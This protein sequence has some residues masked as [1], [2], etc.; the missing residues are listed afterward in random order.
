MRS[1]RCRKWI[2]SRIGNGHYWWGI[3]DLRRPSALTGDPLDAPTAPRLVRTGGND[4]LQ[5]EDGTTRQA[6]LVFDVP[7]KPL[8]GLTLEFTRGRIEHDNVITGGLGVLFILQNELSNAGDLV[9][10]ETGTQNY[11]NN[12]TAPI[13]V[14]SGPAGAVTAIQ[15]GQ[16]TTVPGRITMVLNSALNLSR[17]EV[18]YS[19]FGLHY[20]KATDRFGSFT[21][22]SNWTSYQSSRFRRF[23]TSADVENVGRSVPRVRGQTRVTWRE[24]AWTANVGM[25]YTH[26]YRDLA[27]DGWEVERYYTFSAGMVH[28][29]AGDTFLAGTRVSVGIEN[30]LDREPPPDLTGAFYNQGFINRPAGRFVQVSL[31]RAF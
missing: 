5:P 17:Q 9:F 18:R 23:A 8:S 11:T 22:S 14:L 25:D 13:N 4:R 1:I 20:R 6:G 15:P 2:R 19:D 7:W 12:T 27:L 28:E 30:L 16:S 26:S 21:I 10:R 24:G 3:G 29:F 31:R